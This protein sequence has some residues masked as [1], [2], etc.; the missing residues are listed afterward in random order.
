MAYPDGWKYNAAE[1]FGYQGC[2]A[3]L[4]WATQEQVLSHVPVAE[5]SPIAVIDSLQNNS[6]TLQFN[7]A[8]TEVL[9]GYANS[10]ATV[11]R[12]RIWACHM[13]DDTSKPKVHY[14]NRDGV[15]AFWGWL[16]KRVWDAPLS[17]W[18]V[19][20]RISEWAASPFVEDVARSGNMLT[21]E[22][23]VASG[24][25]D[26]LK[27]RGVNASR[28]DDL[29][30]EF[31][32]MPTAPVVVRALTWNALFI[33]PEDNMALYYATDGADRIAPS[34]AAPKLEPVY[35]VSVL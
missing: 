22:M 34:T 17:D 16:Q 28:I 13:A 26:V 3:A 20:G 23:A 33:M 12:F 6:A 2:K 29:R 31:E 21:S 11:P 7:L 27:T 32:S 24:L 35:S 18:S 9:V 1:A 19:N 14:K 15:P 10:A 4:T 30:I 8:I 5:D 25:A